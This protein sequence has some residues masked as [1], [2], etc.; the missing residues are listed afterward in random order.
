MTPEQ[1]FESPDL[2]LLS[3]EEKDA[4]FI[5]MDR[6]AYHRSVFL[7]GRISPRSQTM[8]R[9]PLAQLHAL[10][11]RYPLGEVC[12]I[13]HVAHCGSTLLARALD[14]PASNLVLREPMALRQLGVQAGAALFGDEHGEEW[15]RRTRLAHQM[16]SRRYARG[17]P[18][19]VK[20]NV[21][22]NFMIPELHA[23]GGAATSI[24]IYFSLEDYLVAILR[25]PN[26][27]RW[28]D[29]V[30]GEVRH[31]ISALTGS[32]SPQSSAETAAL[33]WLAQM[34]IYHELISRSERAASLNAEDL[35]NRPKETILAASAHFGQPQSE[36]DAQ[37]V[38]ESDLFA[39]YSKNPKVAF[40]NQAR[41][42]RKR[43]MRAEL[44]TELAQ[45][46]ALIERLPAARNLPQRLGRNLL[47]G[48]GANLLESAP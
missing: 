17:A 3:F 44:Q 21:P 11:Q 12:Y 6:A 13:F 41:L 37:R 9:M 4:T 26:H 15:R 36:A 8:R 46:R 24:S 10:S 27:R 39:H 43:A 16:F 42:E 45:A 2:F 34:R 29:S 28:V 31:A 7:D 1:I 35:F 14:V 47:G 18:T 38:I 30:S 23:L 33:L 40:T 25:S 19:I 5:D 32:S 20:A 48:E 22:V